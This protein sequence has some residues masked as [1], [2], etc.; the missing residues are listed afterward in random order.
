[1]SP[2]AAFNPASNR[3]PVRTKPVAIVAL[4][5][6]CGCRAD[7]PEGPRGSISVDRTS[8]QCVLEIDPAYGQPSVEIGARCTPM[9]DGGMRVTTDACGTFHLRPITQR[10]PQDGLASLDGY[11]EVASHKDCPVHATSFPEAWTLK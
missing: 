5:L 9:A 3:V 10:G 11:W 7:H 4:L 8:D 1:M 6:L 2:D